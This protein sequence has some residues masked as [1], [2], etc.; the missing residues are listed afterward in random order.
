MT[1]DPPD[2]REGLNEDN[3]EHLGYCGR[4]CAGLSSLQAHKQACKYL[5]LEDIKLKIKRDLPGS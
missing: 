4:V 2:I 5:D 3:D 1:N